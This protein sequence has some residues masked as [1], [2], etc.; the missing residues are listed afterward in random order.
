M[1]SKS[2]FSLGV[3]TKITD[4]FIIPIKL[5]CFSFVSVMRISEASI[6]TEPTVSL[7]FFFFWLGGDWQGSETF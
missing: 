7:I 1:H 4:F 6:I 3:I 2:V 5:I